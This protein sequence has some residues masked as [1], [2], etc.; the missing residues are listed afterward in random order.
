MCKR[1]ILRVAC[2]AVGLLFGASCSIVT[3]VPDLSGGTP[4]DASADAR[5][6][7][8]HVFTYDPPGDEPKTVH[9]AGSFNGWPQTIDAGGWPLIKTTATQWTLTH[10][11]PNGR[12][13]Y[14]L[15]LNESEWI[16]DPANPSQVPDG[17]GKS[18]SVL[19]V[20]CEGER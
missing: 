12:N 8:Q 15:V 5:R 16:A 13:L 19:D 7:A 17:F 2:T 18:N 9:V 1:R 4:S 6:C 14:K 11:L 10:E 20:K 3:S